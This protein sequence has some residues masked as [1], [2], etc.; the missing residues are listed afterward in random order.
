[1]SDTRTTKV[2]RVTLLVIDDDDLGADG[3]R[4]VL[5][6][7]RYPNRCIRPDVKSVETREVEWH[8]KHPLNRRDTADE[9]YRAL[10]AGGV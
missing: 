3:V 6:N 4:E 9:A 8:D 7:A 1:M 5:E 2:H 10:F